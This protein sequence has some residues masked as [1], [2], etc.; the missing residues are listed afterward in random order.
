MFKIDNYI[1]FANI[2]NNN[3]FLF[4]YQFVKIKTNKTLNMITEEYYNSLTYGYK[5]LL[6][7]MKNY[8]MSIDTGKLSEK[9]VNVKS[10]EALCVRAKL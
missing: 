1:R 9:Y 3:M 4:L 7:F 10:F 5:S 8:V 6:C 2:K